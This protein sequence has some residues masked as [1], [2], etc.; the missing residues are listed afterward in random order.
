MPPPDKPAPIGTKLP[1]PIAMVLVVGGLF[2]DIVGLGGSVDFVLAR[3]DDPAWVGFMLSQLAEYSDAIGTAMLLGGFWLIMRDHQAKVEQRLREVEANQVP[4]LSAEQ[5]TELIGVVRTLKNSY[6]TKAPLL[7][8]SI[9]GL[10]DAAA[11]AIEAGNLAP[12]FQEALAPVLEQFQARMW[13]M[14]NDFVTSNSS[15]ITEIR[16]KLGETS[17]STMQASASVN[18]MKHNW[19]LLLKL[20]Q[21]LSDKVDALQA[22]QGEASP[23]SEG[24]SPLSL[25]DIEAETQ[26]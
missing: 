10:P 21:E 4:G 20:M 18:D 16:T 25:P 11:R 13:Q 15:I 6:D 12:Q 5:A 1:P 23:Q 14:S 8:A 9:A 17:L 2:L 7:D 24:G 3:V 22:Q 19:I 26:R